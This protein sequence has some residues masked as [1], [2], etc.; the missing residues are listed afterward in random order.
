MFC[1]GGQFGAAVLLFVV[2]DPGLKAGVMVG[3]L[4]R[5]WYFLTYGLPALV[6]RLPASNYTNY[7]EHD[8][9]NN[10]V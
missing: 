5:S 9:S 2:E 10:C 3:E 6:F 7:P 1:G 4:L 8:F